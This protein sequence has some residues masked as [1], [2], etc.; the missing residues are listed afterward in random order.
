VGLVGDFWFEVEPS[1][2]KTLEAIGI[3]TVANGDGDG[4]MNRKGSLSELRE[5]ILAI[6]YKNDTDWRTH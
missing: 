1:F 3:G 6:V 4:L 2:S 5:P